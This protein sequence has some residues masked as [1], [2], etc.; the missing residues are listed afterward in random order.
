[1]DITVNGVEPLWS[2]DDLAA[3]LGVPVATIYDWRV[4]GRGPVGIRVGR[5]IRFAR[6]DVSAWVASQRETRPGGA[7]AGPSSAGSGAT[8][9]AASTGRDGASSRVR[10]GR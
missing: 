2:V 6:Q 9:S 3:F 7:V 8:Q 1:M 10:A 4:D 5:H